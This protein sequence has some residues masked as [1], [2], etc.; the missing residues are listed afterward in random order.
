MPKEQKQLYLSLPSIGSISD[1]SGIEIKTIEHNENDD[2]IVFV[3]E[4]HRPHPSVHRLI[5]QTNSKGQ[6]FFNYLGV[7]YIVED[8]VKEIQ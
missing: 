4:S 5:L 8:Y 7:R 1:W 2:Y 6:Q 3:A